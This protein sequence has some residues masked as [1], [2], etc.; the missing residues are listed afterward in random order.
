MLQHGQTLVR[1]GRLKDAMPYLDRSLEIE[2]RSA[3]RR[4]RD[5]IADYLERTAD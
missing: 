2:D 5:G 3:V 1:A 4:Y